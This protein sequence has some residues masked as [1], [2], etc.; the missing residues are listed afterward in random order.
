[1]GIRANFKLPFRLPVKDVLKLISGYDFVN[2]HTLFEFIDQDIEL[3]NNTKILTSSL[4][5]MLHIFLVM[6]YK[7]KK[8]SKRYCIVLSLTLEPSNG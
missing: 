2:I 3:I 5:V 4:N 7:M 8:I 1:M 6:D